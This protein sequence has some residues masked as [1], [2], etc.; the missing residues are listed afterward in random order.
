MRYTAFLVASRVKLDILG[1]LTI[2]GVRANLSKLS[3]FM[4]M[5]ISAIW[6]LV[7]GVHSNINISK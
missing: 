3:N 5:E 4:S 2:E 6:Y 7:V 1:I